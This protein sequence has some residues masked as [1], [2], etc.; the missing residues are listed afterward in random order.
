[1]RK[2]GFLKYENHFYLLIL[3]YFLYIKSLT[4]KDSRIPALKSATKKPLQIFIYP[5]TEIKLPVPQHT[6]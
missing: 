4:L 3:L 6:T 5:G 2:A 1:M